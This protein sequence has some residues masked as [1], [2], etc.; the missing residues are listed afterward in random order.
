M[1]GRSSETRCPGCGAVVL[2]DDKVAT[3]KCPFCTTHLEHTPEAAK[4]M[5]PPEAVLP[6]TVDLR[7]ARDAFEGWLGSLWFASI[8]QGSW[9][10]VFSLVGILVAGAE[11][12]L[13]SA[14]LRSA[15]R[16]DW[17]GFVRGLSCLACSWRWVF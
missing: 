8:G 6:F 15:E 4:A 13:R 9:L 5:I 11:R 12:G 7:K 1:P 14:F 2:L 10:L 16:P 17:R 3:E